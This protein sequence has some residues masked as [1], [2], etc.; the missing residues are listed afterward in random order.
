[1]L[2]PISSLK[3]LQQGFC[4]IEEQQDPVTAC[5]IFIADSTLSAE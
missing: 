5:L 2:L 3:Q 1:M 4:T